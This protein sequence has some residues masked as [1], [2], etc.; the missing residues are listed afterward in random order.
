MRKNIEINER[1]TCNTHPH[2]YYLEIISDL[3]IFGLLLIIFLF[4]IILIKS[5]KKVCLKTNT[6]NVWRTP[7]NL[8]F[9]EIFFQLKARVVSFIRL[10][11]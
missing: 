7:F 3:G 4:S 10:I 2:N 9:A 1:I 5:I 11:H 6:N 8:F